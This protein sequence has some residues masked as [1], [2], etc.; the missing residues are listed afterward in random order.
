MVDQCQPFCWKLCYGR[1]NSGSS[2]RMNKSPDALYRNEDRS[3]TSNR[4]FVGAPLCRDP[5]YIVRS[6]QF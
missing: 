2:I 5:D 3:R 6:F 4:F 1:S